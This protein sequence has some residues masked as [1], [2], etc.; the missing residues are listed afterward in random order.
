MTLATTAPEI[1]RALIEAT[2]FGTR[3]IIEAFEA[4]G[5]PHRSGRRLRRTAGAQPPPDADLR[6]R[7]RSDLRLAAS[8]QTPAL[9]SAMFAAVAAGTAGGYSIRRGGCA[10]GAPPRRGLR[11]I[12]GPAVYDRLY[13]EYVRLHDL[14]GRGGDPAMKRLKTIRLETLEGRQGADPGE[15][16]TR[17][18]VAGAGPIHRSQGVVSATT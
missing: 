5:I 12:A 7:H 18:P 17:E 4:G 6:R 13:D 3:V 2:A 10:D 11:P 16:T 15:S 9:G 1:Y 8:P 14:F